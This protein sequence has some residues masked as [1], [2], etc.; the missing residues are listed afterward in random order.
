MAMSLAQPCP[1]DQFSLINGLSQAEIE[2]LLIDESNEQWNAW[3]KAE[4]E[5][6]R[7]RELLKFCDCYQAHPD[8]PNLLPGHISG[9]CECECEMCWDRRSARKQASA[10]GRCYCQLF[11]EAAAH[12]SGTC[13]C[14][15]PGCLIAQERDAKLWHEAALASY[16]EQAAQPKQPYPHCHLEWCECLD[17]APV[18]AA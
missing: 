6:E 18:L 15:C 12:E 1:D 16:E 10:V 13:A 9:D 3:I 14:D 7:E 2:Q 8:C 11:W 4:A 5:E 17:C